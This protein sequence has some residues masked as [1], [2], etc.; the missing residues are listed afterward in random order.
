M[1]EDQELL[2]RLRC[3]DKGALH[4]LYEKYRDDLFRVAASLMQDRHACEDCVQD[5]FV[6]FADT[7]SHSNVP[8][9]LKAYLVSSVSNKARNQLKRRSL[10]NLPLEESEDL[11]CFNDPSQELIADEGSENILK[12]IAKLPY[13]QREVFVLHIQGNMTFRQVARL[14]KVSIKTVQSRYRYAIEKLQLLL[15]KEYCHENQK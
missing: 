4:R 7:S 9:N 1:S 10:S 13:P 12:A 14:Q 2:K 6:G 5:V 15:E 11:S 3:G 8:R